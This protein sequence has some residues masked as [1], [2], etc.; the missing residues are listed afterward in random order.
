M[1]L[2]VQVALDLHP[3]MVAE[4]DKQAQFHSGG[5]QVADD[6]SAMFVGETGNRLQFEDDFSGT[7]KVGDE[8][9]AETAPFVFEWELAFGIEWNAP[10]SPTPPRRTPDRSAP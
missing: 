8:R 4:V 7:D 9:V 10:K 5:V 6:L 3:G 1:A 2:G